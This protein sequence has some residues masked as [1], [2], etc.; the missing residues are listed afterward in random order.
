MFTGFKK[1]ATQVVPLVGEQPSHVVRYHC[2][3]KQH[4]A[5]FKVHAILW[6]LRYGFDYKQ[7]DVLLLE[8]DDAM[9]NYAAH[10]HEI[11]SI[12]QIIA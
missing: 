12:L 3:Q 5:F 8:C 7:T 10:M 11:G 2:C 4:T 9:K 1:K 6:H